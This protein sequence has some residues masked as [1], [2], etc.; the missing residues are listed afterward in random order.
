MKRISEVLDAIGFKQGEKVT[1]LGLKF[2]APP[3][4]QEQD[5]IAEAMRRQARIRTLRS[6][7]VRAR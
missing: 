4:K 3:S 2:D 6:K 7:G 5:R 1:Q